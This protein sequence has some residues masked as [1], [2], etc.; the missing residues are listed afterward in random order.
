MYIEDFLRNEVPQ[1]RL[2]LA[3]DAVLGWQASSKSPVGTTGVYKDFV[4]GDFQPSLRDWIVAR[5]SPR[6]A[7]WA[8]LSRPCGTSSRNGW[9]SRTH[10][11][12][13]G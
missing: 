3:Q 2:S 1:E 6:T 9:F 5:F 11:R 13:A 8:K 12:Y 7:S 10:S 4:L